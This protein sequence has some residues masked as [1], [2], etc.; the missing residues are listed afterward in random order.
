MELRFVSVAEIAQEVH[1]PR[2]VREKLRVDLLGIEAGHRSAIEPQG[3]G[4]EHEVSALERA[5]AERGLFGEFLVA[6][7]V[8]THVRVREKARELVVERGVRRDDDGDRSGHGL[9]DIERSESRPEAGFGFGRGDEDVSCGRSIGAGGSKTGEIVGLAEELGGDGNGEPRCV[10]ARFAEKLIEGRVGER[11][12]GSRGGWGF[13]EC[14]HGV[15]LL[16]ARKC[17]GARARRR[18]DQ[19][20]QSDKTLQTV[21]M[22]KPINLYDAKTHLSELVERAAEGEEIV[23]AKAGKPRARLVSL[24]H[25]KRRRS[26]AFGR[27]LMGVTFVAPDFEDDIPVDLLIG[28]EPTE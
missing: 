9:V 22:A 25:G 24:P 2:A 3:A 15:S 5:V 23:I 8:L 21:R 4:G 28:G 1:F 10:G 6:D 20:D 19:L 13:G 18:L 14:G 17:E 11:R 26:A 27:N 7:E 16:L 12:A